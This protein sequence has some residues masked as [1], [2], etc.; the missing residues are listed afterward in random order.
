MK[1]IKKFFR[2]PEATKG[3]GKS[4]EN[5]RGNWR[6]LVFIVHR[7]LHREALGGAEKQSLISLLL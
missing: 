4:A 7:T 5:G 3:T 6:S 1:F 2:Y